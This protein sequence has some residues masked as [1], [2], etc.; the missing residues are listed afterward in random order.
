MAAALRS[1]RAAELVRDVIAGAPVEEGTDGDGRPTRRA[2]RV[3]DRL[4]A[5]DLAAGLADLKPVKDQVIAME[6]VFKLVK[7]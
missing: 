2:A 3:R 5:V 7:E 4:A 1:G 6:V